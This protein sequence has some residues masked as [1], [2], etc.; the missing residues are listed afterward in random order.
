[1]DAVIRLLPG[2]LGHDDSA[3]EDSFS[4]AATP[5]SGPA[6]L[7]DRNAQPLQIPVQVGE[8]TDVDGQRW[9]T[10]DATLSALGAGDYVLEVTLTADGTER[11]VLTGI[12]VTR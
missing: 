4:Q 7:L 5:N 3:A 9:L 8:K 11:R 10:A 1:M 12:R 2:V 6:R